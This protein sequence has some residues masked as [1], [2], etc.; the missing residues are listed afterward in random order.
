[1]EAEPKLQGLLHYGVT[2][3]VSLAPPTPDPDLVKWGGLFFNYTHMPIPDGLLRKSG[4]LREL[5]Y[6]MGQEILDGGTV[7][8]MCNAGRN[9]SGL[10]SALI[11]RELYGWS[12]TD[13]MECVRH[14]RPR[15]LANPVFEKFLQ[16]LA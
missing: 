3:V 14:H 4:D 8:T 10:L 1:M 15:A 6:E 13:A 5:A 7:L 9:R 11:V 2:T 16:G 12:G